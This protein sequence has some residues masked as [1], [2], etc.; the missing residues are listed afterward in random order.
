MMT[1]YSFSG[2]LSIQS[3]ENIKITGWVF[4]DCVTKV[5][6]AQKWYHKIQLQVNSVTLKVYTTIPKL[7]L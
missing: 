3:K 7:N 6:K 4:T 2:E 5:T 1:Q